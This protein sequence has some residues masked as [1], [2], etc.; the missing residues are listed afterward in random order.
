MTGFPPI[1]EWY[2]GQLRISSFHSLEETADISDW[3][4]E[5]T[6]KPP[7]RVIDEPR[8]G[9]RT[10]ETPYRENGVLSLKRYRQAARIDLLCLPLIAASMEPF[11]IPNLG[12]V[13]EAFSAFIELGKDLLNLEAMPRPIRLAFAPTLFLPVDDRASGYRLLDEFLPVEIDAEDSSDFQYQINRRR[14]SILGDSELMVNRLS[15]WDV[16]ASSFGVVGSQSVRACSAC[17]LTLD[18][19]SVPEFQGALPGEILE[20]FAELARE[21][22]AQGDIK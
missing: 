10:E 2:V 13:E 18:I 1:E 9:V 20:E 11:G 3:L 14:P 19:N 17:R 7:E 8:E 16:M 21:I 22:C 6:G 15:K 5:L 12:H 4:L